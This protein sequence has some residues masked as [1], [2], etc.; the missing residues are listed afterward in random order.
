MPRLARI[1]IP[2][3]PHHVTQ[4]GNRREPI[5]FQPHDW[6]YYRDW[7]G[8]E[9]ARRGVEC[10]A[11]CLM[12]NHVHLVLVPRD[13]EGLSAALGCAHRRYAGF[14]NARAG[15]TGHLFQGRF[16]CVPMDEAHLRAAALYVA[17]N[18]VRARLV[19]RPSAW[20]Y[21]STRARLEGRNDALLTSAPLLARVG[22][23]AAFLAEGEDVC[24]SDVLRARETTGR[25]LGATDWIAGL[26]RV[27]G[28]PLARR[29]PGRKRAQ[30][31]GT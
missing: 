4:R 25:P 7:L 18:P 23:F 19:D 20:R 26:E 10:W 13:G 14:V 29:A 5:F 17:W 22:D 12:P 30:T 9:C 28:R 27:L 16:G 15:W 6:R 11:Y 2:N 8:E 31:R 1:A 21:A 24:A 3:L